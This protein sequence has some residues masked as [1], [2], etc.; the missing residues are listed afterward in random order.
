[1]QQPAPA[2]ARKLLQLRHKIADTARGAGR[3]PGEVRLIAISKTHSP[4]AIE[5]AIAADQRD[6]GENTVQEAL[7]KI[8]CFTSAD[9]TW[10]FVGHLQSNKAKFVPGNFAWLHSLDSV[11]LAERLSRLAV[12]KDAPV[13]ALVEVN[14]TRDPARH[15]IVPEMLYALLDELLKRELTGIKLRGVMAMGPYP[16]SESEMRAAFSSVR[17]LRD[18]C[19]ERFSLNEF[20]ELSMGMSGD[21]VEAVKEGATMVRIGTAIFGERDYG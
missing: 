11:K 14:I 21:Y 12:E 20:T 17:E 8:A 9:V 3:D 1:M 18:H 6:F 2:I 19:R 16:A 4:E 15:G 10:H 7:G 13:N 5:A